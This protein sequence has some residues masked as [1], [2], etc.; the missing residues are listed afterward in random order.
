MTMP[1]GTQKL[2]LDLKV[3]LQL[4]LQPFEITFR[5]GRRVVVAVNCDTDS[6]FFVVKVAGVDVPL[7][8]PHPIMTSAYFFAQFMAASRVP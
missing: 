7:W 3:A 4:L 6:S 5:A 8:N 1:V 2:R